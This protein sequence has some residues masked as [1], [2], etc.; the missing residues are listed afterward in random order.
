MVRNAVILLLLSAAMGL[1]TG[2][3]FGL[4]ELPQEEEGVVCTVPD[5]ELPQ[6]SWISQVDAE[7]LIDD[8]SVHFV[9][10]RPEEGYQ[11]GHVAGA[12]HVAFTEGSIPAATLEAL[13]Q[14]STVI[15]YCDTTDGCALFVVVSYL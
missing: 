15:T 5:P 9:D 13:R 7:L 2:M 11:Q 14:A 1:S 8:P 12:L 3:I 4:P 10:A 6:I